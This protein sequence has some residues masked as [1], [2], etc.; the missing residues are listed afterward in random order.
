MRKAKTIILDFGEAGK[1]EMNFPTFPYVTEDGKISIIPGETLDIEFDVVNDQLA[2]PHHVEKI[3]HKERT[4]E[5]SMQQSK[6]G[7]ILQLSHSFSRPIVADCL[8]Q[9]F[10]ESQ[11]RKTAIQPI[12]PRTPSLELWENKVCQALLY[13]IRFK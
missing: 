6:D 1:Q 5:V 10:D 13:N 2:N 4:L 7:S 12:Q 9:L 3:V 8:V 11:A